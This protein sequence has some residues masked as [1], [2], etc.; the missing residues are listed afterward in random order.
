MVQTLDDFDRQ[1]IG[2][3]QTNGRLSNV[4]IARSLG[5]SEGTVRKR[6][7][8]L[9]STGIIRIKAVMEPEVLGLSASV[10]IGIQAELGQLTP[11]AQQL[12]ALPQVRSVNIVTGTYDVIIEAALP[13]SGHLLAFLIDK[14]STIPGVVR[15][16]TS[17]VVQTVKCPCAW[18]VTELVAS[19]S[20][21]S[22][23]AAN[24]VSEI[25]PGAIVVP[26]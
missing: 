13:S 3:L 16:A 5:L 7:E 15:T 26:R 19:A 14:I 22:P 6:L 10:F 21:Q 18:S 8:R 24:P 20:V 12:A 23:H 9:L 11:I 1:I 25:I 2:L 4:E 17:H